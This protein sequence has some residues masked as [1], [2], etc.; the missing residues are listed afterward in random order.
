MP[1]YW[2]RSQKNATRKM[3][4][5]QTSSDFRSCNL[6]F[7]SNQC[8]STVTWLRHCRRKIRSLSPPIHWNV[9]S[10]KNLGA[11]QKSRSKFHA[12]SKSANCCPSEL[13]ITYTSITATSNPNSLNLDQWEFGR[14]RA[15]EQSRS[16]L[17]RQL[18]ALLQE[19][20]NE[21]IQCWRDIS[22]LTREHRQW[23]K[24]YCDEAQRTK[25]IFDQ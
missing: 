3:R 2:G 21:Q 4:L 8:S 25:M 20:R 24:Q 9:Y 10:W 18:D 15:V 16:A 19:K 1:I 12:K 5:P 17:E 22:V 6:I 14:N 13:S 23:F 7:P 11:L